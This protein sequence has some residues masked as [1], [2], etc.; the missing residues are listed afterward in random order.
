M[1]ELEFQGER[2]RFSM[3]QVSFS[4]SD[5][6][7]VCLWMQDMSRRNY[8]CTTNKHYYPEIQMLAFSVNFFH[9]LIC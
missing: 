2:K 5:S 9:V 6:R 1:I 4:T 3:L 8:Q 7:L